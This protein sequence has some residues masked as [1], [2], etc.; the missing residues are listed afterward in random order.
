M[1]FTELY[2]TT[3][4]LKQFFFNVAFWREV[5]CFSISICLTYSHVPCIFF[6]D[7]CFDIKHDKPFL[8]SMANRGK[9]TNGSQFFM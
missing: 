6:S 5:G 8:L 9:N 2:S 7:E 3:L 1:V 4:R